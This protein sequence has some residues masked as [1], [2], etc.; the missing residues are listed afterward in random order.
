MKLNRKTVFDYVIVVV[1]N[2]LYALAVVL[3]LEPSGLIT[4]GATGVALFFNRWIGVPVSWV[5]F[6]INVVMFIIGFIFLGKRFALQTGISTFLIPVAVNVFERLFSG[7]VLTDDIFL[8]T[9]FGGLGIGISV[10]MVIRVGASTGGLDIP[11]ILLQKYCRIPVAW[12]MWVIDILVLFLQ[13]MFCDRKCLLY[14]IVMVIIYSVVLD[15]VMTIG[16]SRVEVKVVSEKCHEIADVIRTKL[17]RGVTFLEART[18]YLQHE[19]EVVFSVVSARE[20]AKLEKMILQIDPSAFLIVS[21]V[22]GVSGRGFS[23]EKKY[24]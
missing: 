23:K 6:G 19:T 9:L 11:S 1:G 21:R 17:D 12:G 13:A 16:N 3:F 14:G 8:C 5:L 22:S 24:L 18:G 2:I 20:L 10:G 4:G 7:F 15:R